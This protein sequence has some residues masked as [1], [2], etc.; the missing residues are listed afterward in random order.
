MYTLT[1][2]NDNAVIGKRSVIMEKSNCVDDIEIIVNK[3]YQGKLD[4]STDDTA[5]YMKYVTPVTHNIKMTKLVKSRIDNEK[6][7]VIYT[8]PVTAYISAEPGDIEV[9]FTFLKLVPDEETNEIT[10]YI[11]KTQSGIIHI[12]PLTQFDTYE[13]SELFTETDQRLLELIALEKD[14]KALNQQIYNGIPTDLRINSE[15]N[16]VTLVNADGDTGE[17]VAISDL[18]DSIAKELVGVDPDGEQDGVTHIDKVTS[19]QNLDEL[20]K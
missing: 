19:V 1:I 9:S 11:R 20:L 15:K 4:I 6:E 8:I 7:I 16:K 18:S 14:I 2:T 3:L 17:G 12:T 13:P 5:V 10:S